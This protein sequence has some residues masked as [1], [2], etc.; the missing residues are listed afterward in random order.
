MK[1]IDDAEKRIR[2][3][4]AF[5]AGE[6]IDRC[7]LA[8]TAPKDGYRPEPPPADPGGLLDY[9]T[10]P[11]R[12]FRRDK[13]K[14]EHAYFAGDALPIQ[15]FN[16]GACGH[17]GYFRGARYEFKESVWFHPSID[18]LSAP[19][20][21]FDRD[22]FLYRKTIEMAGYFAAHRIQR[23]GKG[24]VIIIRPGE[25]EGILAGLSAKGLYLIIRAGS[26]EEADDLVKAANRLSRP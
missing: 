12:V 7:C 2:R 18:D 13:H 11:A 4:K 5:W 16:L 25:L 21:V 15:Y 1:Y 22:S 23:A 17:A 9:W 20:P 14:M 24:L 6:M 26:A 19:P 8:V 10:N 3:H